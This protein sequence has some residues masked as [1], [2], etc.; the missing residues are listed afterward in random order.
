MYGVRLP[1]IP[2]VKG[3]NRVYADKFGLYGQ[4]VLSVGYCKFVQ[5][6]SYLEPH[7]DTA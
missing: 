1:Y 2:I 4:V 6:P 5:L 3:S 7:S